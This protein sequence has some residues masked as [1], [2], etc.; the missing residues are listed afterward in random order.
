VFSSLSN[1]EIV[2]FR[3]VLLQQKIFL[4]LSSSKVPFTLSNSQKKK[5]SKGLRIPLLSLFYVHS[6]VGGIGKDGQSNGDGNAPEESASGGAL[7]PFEV[8]MSVFTK[9]SPSFD[10]RIGSKSTHNIVVG[11]ES[12]RRRA[13]KL[14]TALV[15]SIKGPRSSHKITICQRLDN[16]S[17]SAASVNLHGWSLLKRVKT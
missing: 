1:G 9:M 5:I 2:V 14:E 17:H 13:V 10:S 7:V 8:E 16:Y 3:L 4:G 6:Y 12:K 15:F 11:F